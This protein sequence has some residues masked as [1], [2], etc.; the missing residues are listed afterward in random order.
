MKN[1][2]IYLSVMLGAL[3]GSALAQETKTAAEAGSAAPKAASKA[4]SAYQPV[5]AGAA[6]EVKH[7]A[8][9]RTP[10]DAFV[11]AQLEAKGLKPSKEADRATFIRRATLDPRK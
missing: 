10:I 7:K 2:A 5:Q 3:G 11:L 1:K 6:P 8:W 4:W 9:V